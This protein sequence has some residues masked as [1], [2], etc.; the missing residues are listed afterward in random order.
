MTHEQHT[1]AGVTVTIRTATANDAGRLHGYLSRLDRSERELRLP[2]KRVPTYEEIVGAV[3]HGGV[4]IALHAER[5]S[6][7]L[8]ESAFTRSGDLAQVELSVAASWRRRGLGRLLLASS[9]EEVSAAG[10]VRCIAIVDRR[11]ETAARWFARRGW[12]Q[13]WDSGRFVFHH[14]L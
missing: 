5:G 3:R 8:G 9:V 2:D 6:E 12:T 13:S 11:N 4:L 10:L 1:I 14:V 7:L